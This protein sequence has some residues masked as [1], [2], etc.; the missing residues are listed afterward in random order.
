MY[1]SQLTKSTIASWKKKEKKKE[2]NVEKKH[3][4]GFH[5]KPNGHSITSGE[6]LA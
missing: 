1:C 4:R 6:Y 2:K 5:C 3:K